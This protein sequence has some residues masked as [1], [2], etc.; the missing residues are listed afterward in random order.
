MLLPIVKIG[1]A[2]L[3]RKC[4]EIS[5]QKL[6][7]KSFREFLDN[8]VETMHHE[9]GVGLA[10]N[11]V[12]QGIQ[13]VVLECKA[14]LRYPEAPNFPLE[15]FIN[16]RIVDASNEMEEDWEGCLSIPGYRGVVPRAAE[17]TFEAW[18]RDGKKIKQTVSGFHARVIQ[19]EVDHIN[20]FF[21]MDRMPDLTT[22]MH[23]DEFNKKRDKP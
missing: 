18:T 3:K 12:G 9:Q 14:N 19:H 7:D 15:I 20:G 13:A 17:V 23:L 6:K 21:Y 22:W 16:P 4:Q 1:N 11:Q 5:E 2:V 8:M 10:A